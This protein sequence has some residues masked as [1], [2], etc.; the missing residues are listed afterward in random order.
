[1]I[2]RRL[3]RSSA[4]IAPIFLFASGIAAQNVDS[5]RASYILPLPPS[6]QGARG[7]MR[8]SPGTSSGTPTA[9]GAEWGDVFFGAGF[10]A[11]TRYSGSESLRKRMDGAVVGGVGL[12]NS[13]NALGIELAYTSFSTVRS[14]FFRTSS[15]SFKVH[16]VLPWNM[17]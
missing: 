5:L 4:L 11:R 6:V 8:I 13:R 1:M 12:G 10:Q 7:A 2:H 14:G 15:F 3:L 17:A 9:Y 16:R